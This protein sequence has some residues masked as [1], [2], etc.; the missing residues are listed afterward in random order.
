M[1]TKE[2]SFA[3]ALVTAQLSRANTSTPIAVR[4]KNGTEARSHGA[5]L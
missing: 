4:L 5:N 2:M 3:E 1:L